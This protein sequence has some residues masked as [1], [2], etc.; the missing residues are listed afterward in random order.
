[1]KKIFLLVVFISLI[2]AELWAAESPKEE[3]KTKAKVA[4][5]IAKLNQGDSS[6]LTEKHY[7]NPKEATMEF[8]RNI[9]SVKKSFDRGRIVRLIVALE[10]K[11][12]DAKWGI[13]KSDNAELA[14]ELIKIMENDPS[15]NVA[16]R[17]AQKLMEDFT[18]EILI[19]HIDRIKECAKKWRNSDEFLLYASLPAATLEE[20]ALLAKELKDDPKHYIIDKAL[21]KHGDKKA[22]KRL[23]SSTEDSLD[24]GQFTRSYFNALSYAASPGIL[25]YLAKG[26]RSD[27]S[28]ELPGGAIMPK[29][30]FCA[31]ALIEIYKYDE[32]FPF[33]TIDKIS[34]E[35]DMQLLEKWCTEK[36]GVTYP[37]TP[38]PSVIREPSIRRKPK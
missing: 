17:A 3:D 31:D 32:R 26:L 11:R 1:M 22:E 28:I 25:E 34:S 8:V 10:Q 16:D 15:G 13:P 23:I 7:D 19:P 35:E 21:A 20:I 6:L 27:K 38:R 2:S 33:P 9:S 30:I 29:M 4:E 36:I 37:D 14:E 12:L 24:E 18:S 5:A